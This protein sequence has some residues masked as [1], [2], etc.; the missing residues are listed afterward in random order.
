MFDDPLSVDR[1]TLQTKPKPLFPFS[2]FV[3]LPTRTYRQDPP[4]NDIRKERRSKYLKPIDGRKHSQPSPEAGHPESS[5][6]MT[7]VLESPG[8]GIAA[9]W[10]ASSD[11]S[12]SA[13]A[14]LVHW[15][16]ADIE[17]TNLA[18][19]ADRTL[20]PS[21][22]IRWHELLRSTTPKR[23][24]QWLLGRIAAKEALNSWR[25]RHDEPPKQASSDEIGNSKQGLPFVI[26]AEPP[27]LWIS[28]AHSRDWAFAGI[29]RAGP[30][31]VDMEALP[32][33]PLDPAGFARWVLD[34]TEQNLLPP[35]ADPGWQTPALSVWCVKEAVAK[36][37]G[38]GLGWK[39]KLFR[40]QAIRD[41]SAR[42]KHQEEEF[43]VK[44]VHDVRWVAAIALSTRD[45]VSFRW[46]SHH[47]TEAPRLV[48]EY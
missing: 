40:V 41:E 27:M 31:G 24:R 18:N 32:R 20:G 47:V 9:E 48:L 19:L 7:G 14:T 36:T 38:K 12:V 29:S 25:I 33:R 8:Y 21:E 2:G 26:G 11:T 45:A 43:S 22:K 42:V 5:T 30:I 4:E 13:M 23:Q 1:P 46:T 10:S 35:P 17:Q 37:T 44:L 39:P 34:P 16:E 15:S 3:R 6:K 28:I